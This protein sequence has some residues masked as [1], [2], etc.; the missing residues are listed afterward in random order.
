MKKVIIKNIK[1]DFF[2]LRRGRIR[3]LKDINLEV[4]AGSFFVILG[5]SGCGKSTLMNI[6]AGI[7]KPSSGE[8]LIGDSTVVSI[9]KKINMSPKQRDAAMVFQSYALYPHMTVFE[10]ISFPLRIAKLPKDDIN[11]KVTEAAEMLEIPDLLNAKPSELSGGQRQRVALG[12]AIVRQPNVLLLDEPLSNLDALLRTSMRAQL[13]VLQKK[14]QVTTIYVTHDQIEAVTLGDKVAV[15]NAGEVQQT[16][17]PD[18]IYN[19]PSNLFTAQF[20][21]TPPMNIVEGRKSPLIFQKLNIKGLEQPDKLLLGI[22]P[23]NIQISDQGL[24]EGKVNLI[25]NL[26]SESIIYI[27]ADGTEVLVKVNKEAEFHEG[28][29]IKLNFERKNLFIFDKS[30]GERVNIK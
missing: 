22:R 8:I 17:T 15:L 23:E 25:S 2:T 1:K 30:N 7:E 28:E 24:L 29:I 9:E 13:K 14:I 5:P 19:N 10:N 26:G 11:R 16:G 12:R 20:I 21:G 18:E 3:A 27:E 6:I 4:D